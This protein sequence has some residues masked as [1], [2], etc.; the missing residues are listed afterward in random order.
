MDFTS[1]AVTPIAALATVVALIAAFAINRYREPQSLLTALLAAFAI[2]AI[3][4][5]PW[6]YVGWK[7]LLV[8]YGLLSTLG[9]CIGSILVLVPVKTIT[10]LRRHST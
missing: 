9:F 3:V 4:F 1:L 6:H 8:E 5:E 2:N 10:A 7:A